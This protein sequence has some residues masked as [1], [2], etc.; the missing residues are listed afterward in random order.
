SQGKLRWILLDEAH[1]LTGSKAA[2]MALLI[3]RVLS[4]FGVKA[5]DVR[6]AITSA[7]VGDG[8]S[9]RLQ[10]FM[11]RLCGIEPHQIEV[12]QGKRVNDQINEKDITD[13]SNTLT[14]IKIIKLRNR[15][16]KAPALTLSDIGKVLGIHDKTS[17]LQAIDLIAKQEVPKHGPNLLPLRGHFF[18]RSIGGV[19]VCCNSRCTVHATKKPEKAL[20]TMYTIA[21]KKCK[22]G[23]PLLELVA[24]RSCGNMI[25]EGELFQQGNNTLGVRQIASEGYEAFH[26]EDDDVDENEGNTAKSTIGW[27]IKYN[28]NKKT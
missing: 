10:N 6:F 18:T 1:T 2:E 19:Y 24:C 15:L 5:K 11:S 26:L 14:R 8:D 3:R 28:K 23:H 7:T 17:Q 25:L 21:D 12:I 27:F 20:G 16:L 13:I 22:C 9:E 4:A